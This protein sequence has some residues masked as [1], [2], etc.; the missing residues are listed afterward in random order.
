MAPRARQTKRRRDDGSSSF[1]S[2][3]E[4]L[5]NVDLLVDQ[6][7][8]VEPESEKRQRQHDSQIETV[9]TFQDIV[10]I[11][12]R[13]VISLARSTKIGFTELSMFSPEEL[14]ISEGALKKL[15]F[16]SNDAEMNR[17]VPPVEVEREFFRR[18]GYPN[19]TKAF[20][21]LKK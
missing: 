12:E 9:R 7:Q 11:M 19:Y 14:D 13:I 5:G 16:F 4:A 21:L 1:P 2:V 3:D 10:P 18:S 8:D 6:L 20:L 17:V 15:I